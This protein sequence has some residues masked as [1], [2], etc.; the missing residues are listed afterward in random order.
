[1]TSLKGEEDL[2]RLNSVVSGNKIA[3][4]R[5]HYLA[6]KLYAIVI[7]AISTYYIDA[8]NPLSPARGRHRV[9]GGFIGR[10]IPPSPCPLPPVWTG[11]MG[12]NR[13]GT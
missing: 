13:S 5:L 7:S 2:S 8:I 6:V 4:G 3:R 12:N 11:E 1:M 10:Y 9:R